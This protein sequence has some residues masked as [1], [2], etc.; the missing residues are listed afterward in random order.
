MV[1]KKFLLAIGIAGLMSG[2]M[3]SKMVYSTDGYKGAIERAKA[4]IRSYG[5]YQISEERTED[6]NVVPGRVILFKENGEV[7]GA[8]QE[9]VNVR[10]VY[11]THFFVDS[12][13]NE[14]WFRVAMRPKGEY[15]IK[16]SLD[17]CQTSNYRDY[18]KLCG[19]SSAIRRTV[20]NMQPDVKLSGIAAKGY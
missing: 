4:D 9:M 5:Y 19:S 16:I 17:G 14:M 2:C 12:L 10:T 1:M 7:S 3:S 8:T 13:G 18:E 20:D 6:N 15:L 11:E